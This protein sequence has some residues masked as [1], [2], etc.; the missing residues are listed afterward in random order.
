MFDWLF[1]GRLTVYILL[2]LAGAVL[3]GLWWQQ[4][5]RRLL[6]FLGAVAAL[7]LLYFLLDRLVTTDREHITA[8]VHDMAEAF[9]NRELDRLFASVSDKFQSKTY[10]FDKKRLRAETVAALDRY[11]VH[12][13][14]KNVQVADIDRPQRT[15]KVSFTALVD[16]G[17]GYR[18]PVTC[19]ADFVLEGE[20][21]WRMKDI[22]FYKLYVDNQTP[23]NPFRE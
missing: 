8:R 1:E 4:R 20:D 12:A 9:N 16:Y 22:R 14:V 10:G 23:W 5:S 6:K 2:L 3:L 19:E 15:A 7:A 17:A 21:Q 11:N 13:S 18:P